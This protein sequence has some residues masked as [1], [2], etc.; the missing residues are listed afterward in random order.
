MNITMTIKRQ[1]TKENPRL[2]S[3]LLLI[4]KLFLFFYQT[5]KD[6]VQLSDVSFLPIPRRGNTKQRLV[7]LWGRWS[8]V[9][10]H[11]LSHPS[12]SYSGLAHTS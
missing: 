12:F 10:R 5:G 11:L 9:G 1:K 4:F 2:Q 8:L 6:V 7:G 3:I